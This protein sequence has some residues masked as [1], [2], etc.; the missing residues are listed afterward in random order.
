MAATL[1]RMAADV[2]LTLPAG[3]GED[4]RPPSSDSHRHHD[5]AVLVF[6]AF[7]GAHLSSRLRIFEF[8]LHIAVACGLEEIQK[9]LRV[10][11]DLDHI[12]VEVDF[13]RVFRLAGFGGGSREFQFAL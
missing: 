2:K 8:E 3:T 10:E 12:P 4:V 7:G 5:I 9:I 13:D 11:A 6:L 1:R